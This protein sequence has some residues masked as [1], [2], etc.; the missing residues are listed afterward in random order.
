MNGTLFYLNVC[1][2]GGAGDDCGRRRWQWGHAVDEGGVG[3]VDDDLGGPAMTA[4]WR[5]AGREAALQ[6]RARGVDL[7]EPVLP[8]K[9][10]RRKDRA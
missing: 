8:E 3:A 2:C 10:L 5:R 1:R 6:E 7:E 9:L 4:H